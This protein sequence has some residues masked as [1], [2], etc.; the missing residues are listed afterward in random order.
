MLFPSLSGNQ[1]ASPC[2]LSPWHPPSRRGSCQSTR[3]RTVGILLSGWHEQAGRVSPEEQPFALRLVDE[4]YH[5]CMF[6]DCQLRRSGWVSNVQSSISSAACGMVHTPRARDAANPSGSC[7]TISRDRGR[8]VGLCIAGSM[9]AKCYPVSFEVFRGAVVSSRS[10]R[11][12]R[13]TTR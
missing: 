4:K 5:L 9:V 13:R 10:I 8:G 6:G 2:P 3:K 1:T 7:Y 11:T 12:E